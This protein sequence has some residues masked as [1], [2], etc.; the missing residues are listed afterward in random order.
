MTYVQQF[1]RMGEGLLVRAPAKLNLTLLIAGKRPDGFHD[2]ETIMVKVDWYDEILIQPGSKTGIDLSCEGPEWAPAGQDNLVCQAGL[3]ILERSSRVR[4]VRLALTKNIPAGTGLGSASSDAAATL[5]GLNHYLDLG[6]PTEE[7]SD[8]AAGLGSDVAFF[9][10]GPMAFCTGRGEEIKKLAEVF[11]FT[12]LLILPDITVSTT[13]VYAHYT[14]DQRRYQRLHEEITRHIRKNRVDLATKMCANMLERS[15]FDLFG[16]LG[17]LKEAVES[18][19]TGPVCLSG[20]GSAM[21]CIVDGQDMGRLELMRD[22][23]TDKTGC[24]SVVVRNN[25]W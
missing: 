10:D 21:F 22:E 16:A 17:E 14:H 23:I 25:R 1:E 4:G 20:S 3:A 12:A 6:L 18:L 2:L 24:R 5:K 9:L 11:D 15:C 8:I 19:G 7:L 13:K